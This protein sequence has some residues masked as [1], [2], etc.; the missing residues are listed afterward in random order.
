[1]K[2]RKRRFKRR[3]PS[4]KIIKNKKLRLKRRQ[5]SDAHISHIMEAVANSFE[6]AEKGL[7]PEPREITDIVE[8]GTF[9]GELEESVWHFADHLLCMSIASDQANIPIKFDILMNDYEFATALVEIS[10]IAHLELKVTPVDTLPSD[11]HRYS[12]IQNAG[13]IWRIHSPDFQEYREE[14]F[15]MLLLTTETDTNDGDQDDNEK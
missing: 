13:P 1:M 5:L 11:D 2:K 15:S 8:G 12:D 14:R 3:Q 9:T 4:E 7:R 10:I 6:M